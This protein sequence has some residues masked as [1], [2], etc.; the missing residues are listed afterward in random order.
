[1]AGSFIKTELDSVKRILSDRLRIRMLRPKPKRLV[2]TDDSIYDAAAEAR[3]SFA[4]R[5][6]HAVVV[7]ITT[8]MFCSIFNTIFT[9]RIYRQSSIDALFS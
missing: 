2:K 3:T 8:Q 7:L 6:T 5:H 1:M 4:L 9:I